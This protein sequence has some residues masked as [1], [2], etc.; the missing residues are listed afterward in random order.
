VRLGD[1]SLCDN[2]R[3]VLRYIGDL[4]SSGHVTLAAVDSCKPGIVLWGEERRLTWCDRSPRWDKTYGRDSARL[5]LLT[6]TV[7]W[8]L[9][10]LLARFKPLVYYVNVK[11][12]HQALLGASRRLG[13]LEGRDY[14]DLTP[15]YNPLAYRSSRNLGRLRETILMYATPP[16]GGM[17]A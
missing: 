4:V 13:L 15:G 10:E 8:D 9:V 12:Y 2:W 11:A 1:Y 17:N 16:R 14:L 7:R 3:V 6:E 5:E